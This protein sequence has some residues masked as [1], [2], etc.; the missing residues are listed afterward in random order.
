[1]KLSARVRKHA[2]ALETLAKA[3]REK[4]NRMVRE[5]TSELIF[6]LVDLAKMIIRGD[7]TLTPLQLSTVRRHKANFKKLVS[8]STGVR[9][10]RNVIQKGGFLP[11]LL[12]PVLKLGLPLLGNLL[13]GVLG[14]GR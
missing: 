9:G 12:G 10:K 4:R 14:G 1:M 7:I 8:K 3:K 2:H 11:A 5:A 6:T 13:G